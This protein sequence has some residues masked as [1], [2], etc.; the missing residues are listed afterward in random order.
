VPEEEHWRN[1]EVTAVN[2]IRIAGVLLVAMLSSSCGGVGLSGALIPVLSSPPQ[3]IQTIDAWTVKGGN[4]PDEL[5]T[6][7]GA[8][9]FA[10]HVPLND[11]L[12]VA[13]HLIAKGAN[14]NAYDPDY[15]DGDTLLRTLAQNCPSDKL[16]IEERVAMITFLA[17]KGAD[18]DLPIYIGSRLTAL[19]YAAGAYSYYLAES[20]GWVGCQGH[21]ALYQALVSVGAD[22]TVRNGDGHTPADLFQLVHV[23]QQDLKYKQ[24]NEKS[25][26]SGEQ[27]FALAAGAALAGGSDMSAAQKADF[28]TAYTK[29]VM[30]DSGGENMRQWQARALANLNAANNGGRALAPM[31]EASYTFKCPMGRSENTVKVPY[32]T[33]ACLQA[34]KTFTR[35]YA[36]NLI[37]EMEAAKSS[38]SSACGDPTCLERPR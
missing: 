28:A 6:A 22:P 20:G 5:R 13:E 4:D 38:C 15:G 27:I 30:T 32:Y 34:A 19:H 23:E 7:L 29:D 9:L 21:P 25:G 35:A 37:D 10:S 14:P 2:K 8:V 12:R 24:K 33:Q 36:C 17:N 18:P 31:Q 26:F 11:R 1:H 16:S 3:A